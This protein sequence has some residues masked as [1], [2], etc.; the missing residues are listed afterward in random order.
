[1]KVV[2]RSLAGEIEI[3]ARLMRDPRT[4]KFIDTLERRGG[5]ERPLAERYAAQILAHTAGEFAERL[6]REFDTAIVHVLQLRKQ[7]KA[8]YDAV[9]EHFAH[10]RGRAGAPLPTELQP[11]AFRRLFIEMADEIKKLEQL[12]PE[13]FARTHPVGAGLNAKAALKGASHGPRTRAG[14]YRGE[15]KRLAEQLDLLEEKY[16]PNLR[17]YAG[18]DRII[19]R[20]QAVEQLIVQGRLAEAS[21]ELAQLVGDLHMAEVGVGHVLPAGS[22]VAKR[23]EAGEPEARLSTRYGPARLENIEGL[24]KPPELTP[25]APQVPLDRMAVER[26]VPASSVDIARQWQIIL[27][28]DRRRAGL[29]YEAFIRHA[30]SDEPSVWRHGRRPDV[31][32]TEITIEGMFGPLSE[33]KVQQ[34]WLDLLDTGEIH[35]IVPELSAEAATQ[36]RQLAHAAEALTGQ[37]VSINVIETAP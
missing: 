2:V 19:N 26:R 14:K 13:A 7:L 24:R 8:K 33:H 17:H 18:A 11:Q 32:A 25:D 30:L 15:A 35:L 9:I 16:W 37:R 27:G 34:L 29:D 10:G 3:P 4:L 6:G 12:R 36:I 20:F 1:M 23:A 28:T 21:A 5:I 31:G 22:A